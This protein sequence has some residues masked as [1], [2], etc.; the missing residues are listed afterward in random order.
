MALGRFRVKD[1]EVAGRFN[2]ATLKSSSAGR[3][4]LVVTEEESG[5]AHRVTVPAR[6]NSGL[7]TTTRC[8]HYVS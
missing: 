5:N 8:H 7:E 2:R 4:A 3:L 1:V 6:R